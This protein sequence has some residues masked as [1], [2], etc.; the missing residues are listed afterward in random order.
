[1]ESVTVEFQRFGDAT[2]VVRLSDLYLRTEGLNPA[3]QVSFALDQQRLSAAM[4]RFD[5]G[6]YSGAGDGAGAIRANAEDVLRQL[7]PYLA[8]FL[9]IRRP[10]DLSDGAPWQLEIVTRALELAQL[11]FEALE[12][13][14]PGL[15]ITRRVRQPRPRP[16]V[17]RSPTPRVLYAWAEPRKNGRSQRRMDVPHARHDALLREVLGEW[18]DADPDTLR[19]LPNVTL[20]QL[21]AVFAD[22]NHGITHL[23]LLAH[24]IGPGRDEH[25]ATRPLDLS[26]EPPG[27]VFLALCDDDEVLSR[28]APSELVDLFAPGVPRPETAVLATCHSGEVEPIEAGGTLA[29]VVHAAGVP[30]VLGSQL[31]LTQAGSDEL[32]ST[33]LAR[34]LQAEDPREALRAT[35][36]RMA[37]RVDETYYDR[38]ALVGYVQLEHDFERTH[39]DVQLKASL[40]RLE[41]LSRAAARTARSFGDAPPDEEQLDALW[42]RLERVR[43]ALRELDE[44]ELTAAQRSEL[45]GL[46]ASALKREAEA[47]FRLAQTAGVAVTEERATEALTAMRAAYRDAA[48]LSRDNHWTWVQALVCELLFEGT[49][50]ER[51]RDWA[52]AWA[53]ADDAVRAGESAD[54][55]DAR[56]RGAWGHGSLAELALLGACAGEEDCMAEAREH[57]GHLMALARELEAPFL[58]EATARQFA[59]YFTWW[60]PCAVS[61]L[62]EGVVSG[63]RELYE[64]LIT[65]GDASS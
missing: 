4:A 40:A 46:L 49:L 65:G 20:A 8:G 24:G 37:E 13:E 7:R 22:P 10:G 38:V 11:P 41:A 14:H 42:S 44:G 54:D 6:H 51:R 18:L 58:V 63:A 25:D 64:L 17:H 15:V 27:S 28:H 61:Q 52:A 29:H 33:F 39:S 48:A 16:P 45:R 47:A 5:Y 57:L 50:A 23:H 53:A 1:M 3:E 21:R 30:V 2:G 43:A 9:P 62:P 56:M 26:A 32:I 35:R 60:G 59:R 31:A 19:V 55:G 12:A 36:D 34:T